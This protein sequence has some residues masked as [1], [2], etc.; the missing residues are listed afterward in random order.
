MKK[1]VLKNITF[2]AILFFLFAA[3][4]QDLEPSV[5]VKDE[6]ECQ[7]RNGGIMITGYNGIGGDVIIPD[8]FDHIP[9]TA[10]G[11]FAFYNKQLTSIV[12]PDTVTSLGNYTFWR[13]LLTTVKIP[14]GVTVI[15]DWVFAENLLTSTRA[16][17]LVI[18]N[19]VTSIGVC[20]FAGPSYN[21]L[22][23]IYYN[24]LVGIKIGENV[25]LAST[26]FGDGYFENTYN[27]A[28]FNKAAGTYYRTNINLNRWYKEP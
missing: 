8:E 15:G 2:F 28:T 4:T 25:S 13:N 12:I 22:S 19:G 1:S 21:G 6:F 27:N 10:I 23:Q 26:A 20:A 11:N 24:P 17:P 5:S 7:I 3:C 18:P 9:V 14:D 16:K